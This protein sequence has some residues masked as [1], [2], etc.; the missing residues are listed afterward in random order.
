MVKK[1]NTDKPNSWLVLYHGAGQSDTLAGHT[2]GCVSRITLGKY[3][4]ATLTMK[5]GND[6]GEQILRASTGGEK[7]HFMLITSSNDDWK[8][9]EEEA[10]K[11]A[12]PQELEDALAQTHPWEYFDEW[13]C[14]YCGGEQ[15]YGHKKNCVW[16]KSY[17]AS[18]ERRKQDAKEIQD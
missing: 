7:M 2:L 16:H 4:T 8:K 17:L 1:I 13:I 11:H 3:G 10:A 18:E 12:T 5:I 9:M 15:V 6:V 14:R